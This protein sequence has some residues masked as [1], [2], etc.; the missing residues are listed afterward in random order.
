MARAWLG[1]GSNIE[2]EIHIRAG[3]RAL[4]ARFGE[5]RLSRVY[6]SQPVGFVGDEFLNLVAGLDTELAP[7][8]LARELDAIERAHGRG[9]AD[10]RYAP[11]RLDID[12][13]LYDDLTLDLPGLRV[14]RADITRYAFVLRPLAELLPDGVHPAL[15]RSYAALWAE[16]DAGGQPLRPV[17]LGG[18]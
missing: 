4:R 13:L 11:R 7:L 1:L 18:L 2:P 14:P 6:A 8:D 3:V 16:F 17:E 9:A 15:G 12:L 10:R 5:L